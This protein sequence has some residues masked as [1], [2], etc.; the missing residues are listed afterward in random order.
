MTELLKQQPLYI[1]KKTPLGIFLNLK[2]NQLL[3]SMTL[4][5]EESATVLEQGRE[6]G[7]Q[8]EAYLYHDQNNKLVATLK[9]P[10]LTLGS[11]GYLTVAATNSVGAFM[12]V[13][14]DKD[15]LLPFNE[16]LKK[17]SIGDRLLVG[18]YMDKSERACATQKIRKILHS[19]IPYNEGDEVKGLI[20][21]IH[22]EMGAF[23]AVDN[24]Y[25][26][27]I[28]SN[29]V[30]PGMTVGQEIEG[31]IIKKREDGKVNISVSKRIDLQM[32]EDSQ[33]ILEMLEDNDGF[34]PYHD[35]TD[36]ETIRKVF[37]LSKKSFK[38][39]IGKLYKDR[40]ID[41]TENGIKRND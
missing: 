7:D 15:V 9:A 39:A 14:Y 16:Q 12:D 19:D 25:Y 24:Q 8:V 23:V 11:I 17:A 36:S 41:I 6:V 10:K 31:R 38:R 33:M 20:Y 35:K 18:I 3:G 2:A 37:A 4:S 26:G 27:L 40:V 22:P 29:E 32:D 30:M 34:L 5:R 1:V 21:D 13:G 28:L